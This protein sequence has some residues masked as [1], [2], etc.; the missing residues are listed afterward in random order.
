M[1]KTLGK[2][3]IIVVVILMGAFVAVRPSVAEEI[4]SD[5]RFIAYD[6]GTVLINKRICC[7]QPGIMGKI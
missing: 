3:V 2:I 6:D 1:G 7:G 5:G 4:A